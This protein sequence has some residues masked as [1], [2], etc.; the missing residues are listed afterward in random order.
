[1]RKFPHQ[2]KSLPDFCNSVLAEKPGKEEEYAV[3]G[4]SRWR[5]CSSDFG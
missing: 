3:K 4:F 2:W 1:V 5:F